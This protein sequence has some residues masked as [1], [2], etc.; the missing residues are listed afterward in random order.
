MNVLGVLFEWFRASFLLCPR[1]RF[2][3]VE[4]DADV[5]RMVGFWKDMASEGGGVGGLAAKFQR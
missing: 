4:L 3:D 5:K 2:V 1:K